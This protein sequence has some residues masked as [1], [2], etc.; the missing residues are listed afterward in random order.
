M[1]VPQKIPKTKSGKSHSIRTASPLSL[2]CSLLCSQLFAC[3]GE[4]SEEKL[5]ERDT[6]KI[7]KGLREEDK[8]LPL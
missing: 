5:Q 2:L 3:G 8:C 6:E 4:G 7:L 1:K